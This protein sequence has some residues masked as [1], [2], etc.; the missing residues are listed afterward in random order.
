MNIIKCILSE[1][2]MFE[3]ATCEFSVGKIVLARNTRKITETFSLM[4]NFKLDQETAN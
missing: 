3:K 1:T 4:S 2:K